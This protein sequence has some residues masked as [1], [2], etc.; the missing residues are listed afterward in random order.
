MHNVFEDYL[1]PQRR[2]NKGEDCEVEAGVDR[3]DAR[4]RVPDGGGGPHMQSFSFTNLFS[5]SFSSFAGRVLSLIALAKVT[6]PPAVAQD[7]TAG[8]SAIPDTSSAALLSQHEDFRAA[9]PQQSSPQ[10]QQGL[11]SS[12]WD[13]WPGFPQRRIR[14]QNSIMGL[15]DMATITGTR[16]QIRPTKT[17]KWNFSARW[18][19]KVSRSGPRIPSSPC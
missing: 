6:M 16:L 8:S 7:A 3:T 14:L 17:T 13:C 18:G 1:N 4:S 9:L 5:S 15:R 10:T 19:V 11:P 12:F 2:R